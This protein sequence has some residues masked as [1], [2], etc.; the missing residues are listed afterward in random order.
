M[1]SGLRSDRSGSELGG[2]DERSVHRARSASSTSRP[3]PSP[4]LRPPFT[5]GCRPTKEGRLNAR[6]S[7]E[8]R[9]ENSWSFWLGLFWGGGGLPQASLAA[10]LHSLRCG[11]PRKASASFCISVA[12]PLTTC[13]FVCLLVGRLV[14]FGFCLVWLVS[15]VGWLVGF[16]LVW[17]C[18]GWVVCLLVCLC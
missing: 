13:R 6:S 17:L 4:R 9:V 12:L 1:S 10:L 3:I 2:W 8:R 16:G 18:L 14:W 5:S 11:R 7:C 15:L